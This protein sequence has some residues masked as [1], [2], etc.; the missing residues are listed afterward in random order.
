MLSARWREM[1]GF[2]HV[3]GVFP[4][5][6]LASFT[7]RDFSPLLAG[8]I[9]KHSHLSQPRQEC[10]LDDFAVAPEQNPS[11]KAELLWGRKALTPSR[12]GQQ[13]LGRGITAPHSPLPSWGD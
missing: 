9:L 1:A 4:F 11:K 3:C 5:L 6:F 2:N 13:E 7:S 10:F 12:D 8:L